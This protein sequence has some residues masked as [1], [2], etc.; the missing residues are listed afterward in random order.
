MQH[1]K[2]FMWQNINISRLSPPRRRVTNKHDNIVP[3]IRP[4]NRNICIKIDI[5]EALSNRPYLPLSESPSKRSIKNIN[6]IK[7]GARKTFYISW[8][9]KAFCLSKNKQVIKCILQNKHKLD[10]TPSLVNF[11]NCVN[12]MK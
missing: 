5:V 11:W 12:F 7:N 6:S 8:E 9:M 2:M 10:W 4:W 1:K 3:L